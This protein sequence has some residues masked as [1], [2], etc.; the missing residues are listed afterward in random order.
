MV[1]VLCTCVPTHVIAESADVPEPC[2]RE[3]IADA[4]KFPASSPDSRGVARSVRFPH[5]WLNGA[6]SPPGPRSG[7]ARVDTAHLG[8]IM[9]M[10]VIYTDGRVEFVRKEQLTGGKGLPDGLVR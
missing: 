4:V 8:H 9:G 7:P 10:N 3:W 2:I 1:R 6:S 5:S